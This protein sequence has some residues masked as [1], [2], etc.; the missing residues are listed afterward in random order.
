MVDHLCKETLIF[1]YHCIRDGHL[2]DV[3]CI[4]HWQVRHG[5]ESMV[6]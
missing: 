3:V 2:L 4:L 5:G 1:G 6:E